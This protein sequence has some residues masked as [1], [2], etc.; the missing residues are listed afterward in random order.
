VSRRAAALAIVVLLVAI[1]APSGGQAALIDRPYGVEEGVRVGAGI[2]DLL[3]RIAG[4]F[5]RRTGRGIVVTSG[6]R[7][8]EEQ[9]DAMYEKIRLGQRL[10]SLYRDTAAATEIQSAYRTNRRAGRNA[11]VRAM[12]AVINAQVGRGLFISRHLSS[13]AVDVRS[14]D[15]SRRERRIF[16]S[17]VA[18]YPAIELLDEG[19]PPHFHLELDR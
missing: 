13:G 15:M 19:V 1:A 4:E 5:H 3:H 9:A 6:T 8:A 18:Q 14:R 16:A 2:A 12:A 17:I 10:T 11:C 7:S